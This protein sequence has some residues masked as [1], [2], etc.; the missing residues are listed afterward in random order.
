MDK[1]RRGSWDLTQLYPNSFG[2]L[3]QSFKFPSSHFFLLDPEGWN[4]C[5]STFL[6]DVYEVLAVK[7]LKMDVWKFHVPV[8]NRVPLKF[9]LYAACWR[10]W[11]GRAESHPEEF[12]LK[13][14]PL[15]RKTNSIHV[16]ARAAICH[17][18][19]LFDLLVFRQTN[20]QTSK[21][22]ALFSAVFLLFSANSG[23]SRWTS[24]LQ[25][26][27]NSPSCI[28]NQ[29]RPHSWNLPKTNCGMPGLC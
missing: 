7:M 25:Q 26:A 20:K 21:Q 19:I 29:L 17:L 1:G 6:L 4:V 18:L 12:L 15:H 24:G 27:A 3:D 10:N 23:G 13:L 9:W 16:S 22:E 11:R 28:V 5:W 8:K 14:C 2:T